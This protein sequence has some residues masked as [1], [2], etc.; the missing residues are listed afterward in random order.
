MAEIKETYGGILCVN[1]LCMPC[2]K[3]KPAIGFQQ[4]NIGFTVSVSSE[5]YFIIQ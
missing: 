4:N 2:S 3:N 1:S 5:E